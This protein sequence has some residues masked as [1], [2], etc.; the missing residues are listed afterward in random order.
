MTIVDGQDET[1]EEESSSARSSHR[2]DPAR[3]H[4]R[5]D[6]E[7][8]ERNFGGPGEET[9]TRI[10]TNLL[11]QETQRENTSATPVATRTSTNA[12]WGDF[13]ALRAGFDRKTAQKASGELSTHRCA[14][15]FAQKPKTATRTSR[16]PDFLDVFR[17]LS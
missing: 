2:S 8:F 16:N 9:M 7:R 14:A 13:L 3:E 6:S 15:F 17:F 1:T 4:I 11:V 12:I 5:Q 10:R